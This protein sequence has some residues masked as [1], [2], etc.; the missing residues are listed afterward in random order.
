MILRNFEQRDIHELVRIHREHYN[1]EFSLDEFD[2]GNYIG[3]FT[4]AQDEKAVLVG[5]VRLIPEIVAVT[6]KSQSVRVR[7]EALLDALQASSYVASRAGHSQLHAFI[8][9]ESWLKQLLRHG[10]RKTAGVSL[11]TNL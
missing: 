1:A 5:G 10:F 3:M 4:A 9:D 8:Q 6:D 2:T 7:R 11:V